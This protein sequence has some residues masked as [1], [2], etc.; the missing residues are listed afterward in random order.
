MSLTKF[1]ETV[2]AFRRQAGLTLVA[3]SSELNTSP[4][5]LSAMETGRNKVPLEWVQKIADYFVSKNIDVNQDKL[6]EFAHIANES[7]PISSL[8]IQ[9]QLLV[10]G[11][12]NS[13]L[14]QQQLRKFAELLEEIHGDI[15]E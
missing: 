7:V 1:G 5:F 2:R 8:P 14:N 15:N 3:M 13:E 4:A 9:H 12:A 11:F 10:A 6:V